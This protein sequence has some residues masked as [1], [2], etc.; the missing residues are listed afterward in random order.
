[1]YREEILFFEKPT[2]HVSISDFKVAKDGEILKT[3]LGSCVSVV[4]YTETKSVVSSMSHYLLPAPGL[5]K[6]EKAPMRY[7]S[8][9]IPMQIEAMEKLGIN[10]RD[11][12]AKVSGGAA[13]F[14][15]VVD[16][17]LG[18][19]GKENSD[20]AFEILKQN[21]I[22][23]VAHDVGGTLGRSITFDPE[24]AKLKITIFGERTFF[25]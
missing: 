12:L 25:I 5:K 10:K 20:M 2:I 11:M 16:S 22:P 8:R 19:V 17:N 21:Q 9:L 4:L 1:M 24:T 6:D 14:P 15:V 7:G 3:T 13:M 23:V 18:D